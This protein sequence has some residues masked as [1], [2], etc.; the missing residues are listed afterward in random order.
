MSLRRGLGVGAL[1][2]AVVAV[3]GLL[4]VDA[5]ARSALEDALEEALE[6]ALP[7]GG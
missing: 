6:E 4:A 7:G 5:V 1:L 2:A 3:A